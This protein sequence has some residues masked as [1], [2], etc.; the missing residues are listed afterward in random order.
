MTTLTLQADDPE[1]LNAYSNTGGALSIAANRL[2]YFYDFHGP[3]FAVDTA[4]SSSL[5]AVH[6]ACHSL[7]SGASNLALSLRRKRP[8]EAS[9]IYRL[10]QGVDAVAGWTLQEL[11][12][13]RKWICTR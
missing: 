6:E 8:G 9:P 13:V 7:W 12:C 11:R 1:S 4:C 5:V 3:S 10:L 2:S